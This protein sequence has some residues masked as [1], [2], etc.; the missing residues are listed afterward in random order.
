MISTT[1]SPISSTFSTSITSISPF[2]GWTDSHLP[3][4]TSSPKM[5]DPS[6][7]TTNFTQNLNRLTQNLSLANTTLPLEFT[8]MTPRS[9]NV[10][11]AYSILFIIAATGN[12]TVFFSVCH[13][14]AKLKW[15]ITVLMLHLSIADLIVTFFLMPLEICWRIT[16]QWVG[17]E[18]LCKVCQFLRAFGLYLS[19]N[20]LICISLDRFIAIL[21]PL[22]MVGATRRVK[23][24]IAVAW[25]A[26]GIFSAPQVINV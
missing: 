19:S 1:A 15:R 2:A 3:E 16:I 22:R 9:R 13:Q 26:A 25:L 4:I 6:P 11:V 23:A 12:L 21:F 17:G 20:I 10:V 8:E 24:M 5:F 14:L 7:I 18:V